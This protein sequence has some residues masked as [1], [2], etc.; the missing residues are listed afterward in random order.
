MN[1]EWLFTL[2]GVKFKALIEAATIG[3]AIMLMPEQYRE[4]ITD[5]SS[6]IMAPVVP[7]VASA[8]AQH[9]HSGETK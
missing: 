9:Q 1:S 4:A 7:A 6:K 5:C 2:K 8:V 3:Q